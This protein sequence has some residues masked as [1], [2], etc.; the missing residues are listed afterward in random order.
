[1]KESPVNGIP[2]RSLPGAAIAAIVILAAPMALAATGQTPVGQTRTREARFE[3]VKAYH[4]GP[5]LKPT[6]DLLRSE[7]E[8]DQKMAQWQIEQ[9]VVGPEKAPAIDWKHQSAVV[10]SLGS[11]FGQVG[12]TVNK[13]AVEGDLTILDLHFEVD[14]QWDP[15]GEPSH[16]AVI[17]AI[18]R[19]DIKDV[20]IRC[21]AVVDGLPPG[22]SR[23]TIRGTGTGISGTG[24]AV[25]PTPENASLTESKTTWGRV[26]A[27]YRGALTR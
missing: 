18:D 1:M 13:C 25:A 8:W 11:Q 17:L 6:L 24:A 7:N 20:E 4:D 21:D 22:L 14:G 23:K 26:K 16:P 27:D 12:V 15:F 2:G 9:R 10:L 5:W 19:A 3:I